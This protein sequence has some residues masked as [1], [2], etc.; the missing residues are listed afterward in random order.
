M[1]IT[2]IGLGHVGAVAAA[3]LAL[4]G[5]GVVATDRD[6][7]TVD[8]LKQGRPPFYEP[9]LPTW[10]ASAMHSGNLTMAHMD[11]FDQGLGDVALIAVGT[12]ATGE[13]AMGLRDVWSAI[14][15]IKGKHPPG[16]T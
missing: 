14:S 4:S 10:V 6:R 1:K 11:E 13:D 8:A 7:D 16:A 9:G 15:W 12:Q 5:H 3:A 2:V